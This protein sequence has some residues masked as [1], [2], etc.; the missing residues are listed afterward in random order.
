[1]NYR[2]TPLLRIVIPYVIGI[3]ITD[4]KEELIQYLT[5]IIDAATIALAVTIIVTNM[6]IKNHFNNI[7]FGFLIQL[8][9]I[10]L[11]IQFCYNHN[12][13]NQDNHYIKKI[14]A[15]D[16]VKIKGIVYETQDKN[17][18]IKIQLTHIFTTKDT[19]YNCTGNILVYLKYDSIQNKV[20]YGDHILLK[21]KPS[22]VTGK[23][24]P[25]SFDYKRYL[26]YQN[27][28]YTGYAKAEDIKIIEQDKGSIVWKYAYQ[29]RENLLSILNR[30]FTTKDEYAVATALLLGYK[31][32]LSDELKTAYSETGSM[33]ALAVSGT[34]VGL[35]YN[36]MLLILGYIPL[37]GKKGRAIETIIAIIAIWLFTFI[38]GATASVLRASVMFSAFLI[39]KMMFRQTNIWN[40][41]FGSAFVL[42]I[43]NPY[44]LF[45][46]GFQLSYT[47]VAGLAFFYPLLYKESPIIKNQLLDAAWKVL[48][49]GI[50]AQLGTLPLSIYYFHQFPSYFWLSGWV[51]VLGG[52]LFL[53]AGTIL[54]ILDGILP[55]IALVLGNAL[56]YLTWGMNQVILIIQKL[57]GSVISGIWIKELSTIL[58]SMII[59][60]SG[61]MIIRK[62]TKWLIISLTITVLF[63]A[64]QINQY[65]EQQFTNK[66]CIYAVNNETMIDLFHQKNR[67]SIA[68]FLTKKQEDYACKNHRWSYGIEHK[69]GINLDLNKD[70]TYLN[71]GVKNPILYTGNLRIAVINPSTILP[72]QKLSV[73]AIVLINNPPFKLAKLLEIFP[74]NIIVGDGSN[75]RENLSVWE[76]YCKNTYLKFH[77]VKKLGA[78]EI[79]EKREG[80]LTKAP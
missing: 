2:N 68:S 27:I 53:W 55:K 43:Y 17:T 54:I 50:A 11:G 73:N 58:L 38:T 74:C 65:F 47:A 76:N 1:M 36:G 23:Q 12:E 59:I 4:L 63:I 31:E 14:N 64:I 57:P 24:N 10:G 6:L 13:L 29:W 46:A 44:L 25:E 72:N 15:N 30:Y 37:K 51:V 16:Q 33:H 45:D 21:I 71:T 52:A 80:Y 66:I 5:T 20:K 40:I 26:H 49:V 48:L 70:T 3:I 62:S 22:L 28:H 7:V 19:L 61:A 18:K 60:S 78:W 35:L 79:E 9:L 69:S 34:H 56:Y 39:G 77:N 8:Q 42:L 75:S 32:D 41:L 67:I